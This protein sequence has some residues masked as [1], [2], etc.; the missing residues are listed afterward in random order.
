MAFK[1]IG[2]NEITQKAS[3]NREKE[4]AQELKPGTL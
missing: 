2:L 3:G 4:R 1:I